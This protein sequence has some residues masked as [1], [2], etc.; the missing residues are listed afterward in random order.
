MTRQSGLADRLAVAA[1]EMPAARIPADLW[2]RGLR[3]HRAR[4]AVPT[5]AVMLLV[6][7]AAF[8]A[9]GGP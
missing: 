4:R 6:A 5:A 7:T 3:R 8:A 2:R 9:A 1:E